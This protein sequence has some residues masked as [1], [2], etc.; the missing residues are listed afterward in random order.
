[1]E[2]VLPRTRRKRRRRNQKKTTF[3]SRGR[4]H[5]IYYQ[6]CSQNDLSNET[7]S[8]FCSSFDPIKYFR[9]LQILPMTTIRPRVKM[10]QYCA[11]LIAATE[12]QPSRHSFADI[13]KE[14]T[15]YFSNKD[16]DP[17][18]VIDTGALISLTPLSSDFV[19]PIRPCLLSHLSGLSNK[20]KVVGQGKASWTIRDVT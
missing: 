6:P 20:T 9:C 16:K 7:I 5:R 12:L 3:C 4:K 10:K 14:C 8:K 18:I 2:Y 15:V 17:P 1:M 11:A 19:G 13:S